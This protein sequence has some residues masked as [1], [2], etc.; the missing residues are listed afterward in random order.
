[1]KDQPIFKIKIKRYRF[2]VF[3]PDGI[4]SIKVMEAI[5]KYTTHNTTTYANVQYR[6]GSTSIFRYTGKYW[7]YLHKKE[8]KGTRV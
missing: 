3:P 6:D 1:M 5:I 4:P 2:S 7:E 8:P